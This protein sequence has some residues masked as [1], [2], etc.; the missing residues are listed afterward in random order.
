LQ[1]QLPF[2]AAGLP[3]RLA[4]WTVDAFVL[5]VAIA[6]VHGG[7]FLARG[8]LLFEPAS[9]LEWELFLFTTVSLPCWCYFASSEG[10]SRMATL[11]KR[12]L[13]LR[14]VDVYG[15]RIGTARAWLRTAVKLAPWEVAHVAL[16]FPEPVFV[17]RHLGYRPALFVAYALAGLYLAAAMLTLKK[18]S[19][20]DLAAGTYV[21]QDAP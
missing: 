12:V 8:K 13:G 17:T 3:P 10:S 11:G 7:I 18:Q 9:P 16:C 1:N 20:H 14:V 15:S 6:V 21:A 19:V 2:T 4:A 5:A